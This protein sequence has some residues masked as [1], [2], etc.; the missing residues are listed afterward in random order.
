MRKS[1]CLFLNY[2]QYHFICVVSL[3]LLQ[4][5]MLLCFQKVA[6]VLSPLIYDFYCGPTM[7]FMYLRRFVFYFF[8]FRFKFSV[9][10]FQSFDYLFFFLFVCLLFSCFSFFFLLFNVFNKSCRVLVVLC[11]CVWCTSV[12]NIF[13]LSQKTFSVGKC[14]D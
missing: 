12:F 4:I 6:S 5:V 1:C 10:L 2:S 14:C 11:V 8:K 7:R 3:R 13:C 9:F